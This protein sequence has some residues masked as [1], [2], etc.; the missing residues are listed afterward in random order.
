MPNIGDITKAKNLGKT[1]KGNYIW[2]ECAR[3]HKGR[4]VAI[5]NNVKHDNLCLSCGISFG[6]KQRRLVIEERDR[7]IVNDPKV[8]DIIT[9]SCLI[10]RKRGR[11]QWVECLKCKKGRWAEIHARNKPH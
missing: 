7:I 3:C 9:S 2:K 10:G 5:H 8:G 6:L 4:W 11:F 1:Y